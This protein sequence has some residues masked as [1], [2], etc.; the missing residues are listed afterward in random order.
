MSYVEFSGLPLGQKYCAEANFS[1]P[2]FA[3]AASPKS[4]PQCVETVA[5]SGE[6]MRYSLLQKLE[7]PKLA[8]T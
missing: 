3:M 1:F 4:A 8:A 7:V 6:E 2:T 5:S